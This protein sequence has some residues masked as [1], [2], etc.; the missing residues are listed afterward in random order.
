MDGR[1]NVGVLGIDDPVIRRGGARAKT[2]SKRAQ[3]AIHSTV[4]YSVLPPAFATPNVARGN[5]SN[6]HGITRCRVAQ[7]S[8]LFT[9]CRAYANAKS[10]S[11][12]D[13]FKLGRHGDGEH[14]G[15][16]N[17]SHEM[18]VDGCVV[19]MDETAIRARLLSCDGR[20]L[21]VPG[22]CHNMARQDVGT[23]RKQ[24][25]WTYTL[26]TSSGSRISLRKTQMENRDNER[27]WNGLE[28]WRTTHRP[29]PPSSE[30]TLVRPSSGVR[31]FIPQLFQLFPTADVK[32]TLICTGPFGQPS[33][34][35]VIEFILLARLKFRTPVPI[36]VK[37]V[38]EHRTFRWARR[39]SQR[40]VVSEETGKRKR[41]MNQ[42]VLKPLRKKYSKQAGHWS[43][44]DLRDP[45]ATATQWQR[46]LG[47]EKKLKLGTSRKWHAINTL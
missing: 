4:H 47:K 8:D 24:R 25:E 19:S 30:T 11:I 45:Q 28:K 46:R 13:K 9:R 34:L 41:N 5:A 7:I 20:G 32:A 27:E 18:V 2:R 6:Q 21:L 17:T 29:A 37:A 12:H 33:S 36:V 35:T 42:W 16:V 1:V 10:A 26:A 15:V 40:L 38:H 14:G 43:K 31:C 23:H 44:D 3:N 22:K 39:L